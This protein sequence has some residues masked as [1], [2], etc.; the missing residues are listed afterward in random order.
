MR[1]ESNVIQVFM[2]VIYDVRNKLEYLFLES[3]SSLTSCFLLG[4]E[5]VQAGHMKDAQL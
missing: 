4:P 5:F 3:L 1:P 2:S